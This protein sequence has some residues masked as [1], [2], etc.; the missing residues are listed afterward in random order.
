MITGYILI[1]S[2][3]ISMVVGLV[4]EAPNDTQSLQNLLERFYHTIRFEILLNDIHGSQLDSQ[5][6]KRFLRSEYESKKPDIVIFIRDL[7]ALE[8]DAVQL[9]IRKQY[10]RDSNTIV[11]KKGIFLLNIFEIEALLLADIDCFN[12]IYKSNLF[13]ILDPMKIEEPKEF[14]K[15]ATK[16]TIASYNESHNPNL[17]SE[18]NLNTLIDNCR[19]FSDFISRFN[20]LINKVN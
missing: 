4:G 12:K 9:E 7:D 1:W 19:Y 15:L 18:L 5:K 3:L 17:F 20:L 6:T 13:K 11:N 14:L 10:F 8:N 2:R 16:K